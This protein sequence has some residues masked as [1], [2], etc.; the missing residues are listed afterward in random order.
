MK[1]K[2]KIVIKAKVKVKVFQI[3]KI[4]KTM[5]EIIIKKNKGVE[6]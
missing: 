5:K 3:K 1:M 4:M 6:V 2:N